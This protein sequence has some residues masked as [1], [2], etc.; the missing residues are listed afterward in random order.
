MEMSHV[1]RPLNHQLMQTISISTKR[2]LSL[3]PKRRA[4]S[5]DKFLEV[6]VAKGLVIVRCAQCLLGTRA[7][8]VKIRMQFLLLLV[9]PYQLPMPSTATDSW[10]NIIYKEV[11]IWFHCWL[12]TIMCFVWCKFRLLHVCKS[13]AMKSRI[14]FTWGDNIYAKI[15]L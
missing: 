2:T 3:Q 1:V 15:V 5:R 8:S 9:L 14:W 13:L 12:K 6:A 4:A 11:H 7:G 10:S